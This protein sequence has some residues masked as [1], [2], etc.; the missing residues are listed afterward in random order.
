MPR[1]RRPRDVIVKF[2]SYRTRRL[3][4]R[5]RTKTKDRG[6]KGVF[7]NEDLTKSRN[8]LLL[9]SSEDGEVKSIEEC[10]V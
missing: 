1:T 7:I 3:V 6:Y 4:Y 2:I 5:A 9:K 10:M 8:K